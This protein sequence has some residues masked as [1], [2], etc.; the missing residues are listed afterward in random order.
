MPVRISPAHQAMHIYDLHDKEGRA[1]AFQIDNLLVSRSTV[2]EIV[3]SIAG[4]RVH[5]H[6]RSWW[7]PDVF[8]EFEVG[9]TQFQ[10]WEPGG[11]NSRYSVRLG[12]R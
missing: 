3:R 10:A 7:G 6:S 8:C 4:A 2:A 5:R 1:F 12:R 9:G 11:D